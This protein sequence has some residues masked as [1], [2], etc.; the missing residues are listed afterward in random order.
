[1]EEGQGLRGGTRAWRRDKDLVEARVKDLDEGQG[2]GVGTR[3]RRQYKD[4]EKK[5]GLGDGTVKKERR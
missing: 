1:M 2:P 5:L 3:T 4:L